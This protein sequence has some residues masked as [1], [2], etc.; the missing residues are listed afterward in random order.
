[1]RKIYVNKVTAFFAVTDTVFWTESDGLFF[2]IAKK[3][4]KF[5][6]PIGRYVYDGLIQSLGY[7][8]NYEITIP[9]AEK[10]TKK[11]K[12]F[13]VIFAK[14]KNKCSVFLEAGVIVFDNSIKAYPKFVI[15]YILKHELGHYRYKGNGNESEKKCDIFASAS[16]LKDGYNFSQIKSAQEVCLRDNLLNNERREAN[17]NYLL[18]IQS[19]GQKLNY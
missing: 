9:P 3:G 5:N 13:R 14:N 1:M 6:L 12:K 7:R 11:P 18:N 8:L 4:T 2:Y 17:I 19:S 16:M 15:K 10:I